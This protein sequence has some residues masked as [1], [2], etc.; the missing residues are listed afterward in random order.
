MY[1]LYIDLNSCLRQKHG[2]SLL[3][4]LKIES[5]SAQTDQNR[6]P[7][8]SRSYFGGFGRLRLRNTDGLYL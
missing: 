2:F 1:L 3:F 7:L 6:L 8:R 4:P 5:E